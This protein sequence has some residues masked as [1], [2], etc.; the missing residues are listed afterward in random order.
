VA[1]QTPN[2]VG[3]PTGVTAGPITTCSISAG[4]VLEP[5]LHHGAG[6]T[7]GA[8]AAFLAGLASGSAYLNIHTNVV[9][10]GEIRGFLTSN[11]PEPAGLT[12]LGLGACGAALARLRRRSIRPDQRSARPSMK[13][14]TACRC[15]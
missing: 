6:R 14:Q 13:P 15:A 7:F 10:G 8:E 12:L 11:V 1:T 3:F 9:P 2:F 5:G 4:L